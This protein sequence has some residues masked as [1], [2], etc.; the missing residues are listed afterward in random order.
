MENVPQGDR[1][2]LIYHSQL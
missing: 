2:C 1:N